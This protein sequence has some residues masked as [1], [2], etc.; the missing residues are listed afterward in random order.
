MPTNTPIP[1]NALLHE[2][3]LGPLTDTQR[4]AIMS[5]ATSLTTEARQLFRRLLILA[6]ERGLD[7]AVIERAAGQARAHVAGVHQI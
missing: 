6:Q 2:K 1:T 7:S 4:V 3:T 5:Q